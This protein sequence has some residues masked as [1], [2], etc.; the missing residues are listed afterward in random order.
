MS[1]DMLVP[2][3]ECVITTAFAAIL[4]GGLIALLYP[5]LKGYALAQPNARSS[6]HTPTPQGGGIAV[7]AAVVAAI[8]GHHVDDRERRR[9][10][11]RME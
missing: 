10:Q 6:H 4:S 2:L 5:L 1:S 9:K 3:A 8:G 11:R 7:V